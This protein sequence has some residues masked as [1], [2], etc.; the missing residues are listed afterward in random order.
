M[1]SCNCHVRKTCNKTP[2][3]GVFYALINNLVAGINKFCAIKIKD[4]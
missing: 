2:Q 4:L 3:V 1:F